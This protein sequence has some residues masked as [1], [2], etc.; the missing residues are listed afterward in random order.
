FVS[1]GAV[2][3]YAAGKMFNQDQHYNHPAY[4]DSL[5]L[6]NMSQYTEYPQLSYYGSLHHSKNDVKKEPPYNGKD[7]GADS[8]KC[9]GEGFEW[10]GKDSPGGKR[11]SWHNEGTQESLHPDLNHP[12]PKKPHWDYEGP[13]Y[14]KGVRLN[15]DGTWEPK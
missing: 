3:C 10:K 2:G 4:G 13:N 14:P 11:G 6:Y 12:P 7:L 8:S 15:L 5:L 1:L 9:P